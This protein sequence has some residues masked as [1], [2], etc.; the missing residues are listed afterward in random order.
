MNDGLETPDDI[1]DCI[2]RALNALTLSQGQ[3]GLEDLIHG[4]SYP[5]SDLICNLLH[6]AQDHGFDP[7]DVIESAL[8]HYE[9]GRISDVAD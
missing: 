2:E 9:A 5:I 1:A 3:A 6:L 8:H 7:D 4:E